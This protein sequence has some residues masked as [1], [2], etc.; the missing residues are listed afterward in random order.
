MR[1]ENKIKRRKQTQKEEGSRGKT[2]RNRGSKV[3]KVRKIK[4]FR[5][6]TNLNRRWKSHFL[7]DS[8]VM[9]TYVVGTNMLAR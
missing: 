3:R 4:P 7:M 9:A 5:C 6:Q 8:S 1:K 2:R